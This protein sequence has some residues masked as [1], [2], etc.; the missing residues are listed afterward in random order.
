MTIGVIAARASAPEDLIVPDSLD[1]KAAD[2]AAKADAAALGIAI[3]GFYA[4]TGWHES[5]PP[6]LVFEDGSFTLE[7]V[8]PYR[9]P[10]GES[11]YSTDWEWPP[12]S[13]SEGVT[14]G[15]QSGYSSDTWCLWVTA[16]DGDVKDWQ[17]TEDGVI[18]GTCGL[19]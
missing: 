8:L 19:G 14:F 2:A 1:T 4:H 10:E 11:F 12:T 6:V 13:A 15:G 18:E 7:P 3:E 17:V 5:A 16:R 9:S